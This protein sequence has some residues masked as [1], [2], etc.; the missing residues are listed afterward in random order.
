M[1]DNVLLCRW[2]WWR[3]WWYSHPGGGGGAGGIRTNLP[4][5]HQHGGKES[6]FFSFELQDHIPL[7]LVQVVV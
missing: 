4:T 1:V 5:F 2:R 6:Q 3:W 7:Q